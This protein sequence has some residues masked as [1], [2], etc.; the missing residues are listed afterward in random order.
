MDGKD[1]LGLLCQTRSAGS[2]PTLVKLWGQG[3]VPAVRTEGGGLGTSGGNGSPRRGEP[4][5]EAIL[6]AI[7]DGPPQ[8]WLNIPKES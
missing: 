3:D 8:C 6:Q 5:V 1:G 4:Q 2:A 7:T